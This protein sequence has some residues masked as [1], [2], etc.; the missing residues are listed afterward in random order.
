MVSFRVRR[1]AM[2]SV[3]ALLASIT[4]CAS[5]NKSERGALIGAAAGGL[6]GGVIGKQA[7]S[8]TKGVLIGAAVGGATGAII[9]RQMDKQAAELEQKIPGA[10][11]E[12]V[13]EGIQITFA[14]GLLYDFDSDVVRTSSRA[15]LNQLAASLGKY[16]NTSLMI[17]GHTD[18]VGS[19]EYN[20]DLSLRRSES[21]AHYLTGR[22]VN[23]PIATRG[24]G[25]TEPLAAN[26]TES[27]RMLNRR[28]EVA[29]YANK[30]FEEAAQRQAGER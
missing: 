14:S 24:M 29:I 19:A 8:T 11:V 4:G 1:I 5:M 23:R 27:G 26:E 20:R 28:V 18:A 2:L 16:P 3:L 13:G 22:G 30:A 9:G 15:N 6:A 7:G 17:V 10:T 21:A 25:E 12:R